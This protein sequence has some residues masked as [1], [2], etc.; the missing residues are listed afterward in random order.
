[1]YG[2]GF[3]FCMEPMTI[4]LI[5]KYVN[6]KTI[7]VRHLASFLRIYQDVENLI[8]LFKPM[9]IIGIDK[10]VGWN[11]ADFI[12]A[13]DIGSIAKK[14]IKLMNQYPS[15]AVHKFNARTKKHSHL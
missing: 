11:H 6:G 8:E 2:Q 13:K 4:S 5:I 15:E 3:T 14:I 12:I 9:I 10:M 1:M 7:T